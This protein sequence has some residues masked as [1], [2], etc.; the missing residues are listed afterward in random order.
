MSLQ[1]RWL[2][3]VR[4]QGQPVRRAGSCAARKVPPPS[5]PTA[6]LIAELPPPARPHS[7]LRGSPL[8][9][10]AGAWDTA[11]TDGQTTTDTMNV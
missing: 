4:Y 2:C 11:D 6:P 1:T 8:V 9:P 3:E 10:R 7:L 5:F